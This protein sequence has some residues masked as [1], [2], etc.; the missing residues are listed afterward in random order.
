[1]EAL[2]FENKFTFL[3]H[4]AEEVDAKYV[5]IPPLLIQP[6][7]E[8]A[9]WHGLLHKEGLG[10]ITIHLQQA[11]DVLLCT[12][13][14]DGIGR[15]R[16][17]ELK[18]KSAT[19]KKSLGMQITAQRLELLTQLEGKPTRVEIVDLV[20]AAGEACGTRVCMKIPV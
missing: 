14:D 13:E 2:R 9:I 18:S 16:A 11:G 4:C 5:D 3:I 10:N 7:V 15:K 6:Y 1:M 8:N 19:K 17:A 20:D 12:I